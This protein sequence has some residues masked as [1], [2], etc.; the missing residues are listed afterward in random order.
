[1]KRKIKEF[2]NNLRDKVDYGLRWL[3]YGLSPAGRL[4]TI[5]VFCIGFGITS[6]YMTVSSIYHIGKSDAKK[7]FLEM[8]HFEQLKLQSQSNDSINFINQQKY[9]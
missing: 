8:E 1:M 6:I 2:L 5:L 9:E 4:I 3:C 7:E